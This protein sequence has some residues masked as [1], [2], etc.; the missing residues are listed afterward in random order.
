L[1]ATT[2]TLAI[3]VAL[4]GED[5]SISLYKRVPGAGDKHA[6]ASPIPITQ[7]HPGDVGLDHAS[8]VRRTP[9]SIVYR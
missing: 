6:V 4:I 2:S 5:G 8:L 1:L 3:P 7:H 9:V